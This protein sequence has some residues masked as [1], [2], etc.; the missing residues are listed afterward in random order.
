M[1]LK[2]GQENRAMPE[3]ASKHARN[4]PVDHPECGSTAIQG[5]FAETPTYDA[6]RELAE[7]Y[8]NAER[9]G[10]TLQPTALVH[11]AYLRLLESRRIES[12]DAQEF[13]YAVGGAM[14]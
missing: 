4:G 11:E 3:K 8:L 9:K 12:L 14:R 7:R 1:V 5:R 10:H 13:L 6:M 2:T